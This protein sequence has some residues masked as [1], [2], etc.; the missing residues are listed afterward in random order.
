MD[1]LIVAFIVI[2]IITL[3]ALGTFAW[4]FYRLECLL[5][6]SLDLAARETQFDLHPVLPEKEEEI[7][8][9]VDFDDMSPLERMEAMANINKPDNN[10]E[11][12][13]PT[14]I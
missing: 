1:V 2:C 4:A 3:M 12:V 9:R 5:R 10:E 14:D 6:K 7:I 11:E 13:K 8:D